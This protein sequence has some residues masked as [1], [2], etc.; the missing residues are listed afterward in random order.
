MRASYIIAINHPI[1]SNGNFV[2]K[3]IRLELFLKRVMSIGF[4]YLSTFIYFLGTWFSLFC[5][6][7]GSVDLCDIYFPHIEKNSFSSSELFRIS[8]IH[9]T[10]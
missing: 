1:V 7:D 4:S 9:K 2:W 10:Y 5:F 8:G 3:L 6:Y